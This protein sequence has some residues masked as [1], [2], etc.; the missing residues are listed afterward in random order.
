M[1]VALF[2]LLV[3]MSG[4]KKSSEKTTVKTPDGTME[5]EDGR[6]ELKTK[7]GSMVMASQELPEG[8]P[9]VVMNGA[10]I[11]SSTHMTQPD[12]QELFQVSVT[13]SVP[14][15]EVASFYEKMFKDKGITVSRTEQSG[16]GTQMIMLFGN[17]DGVDASAMI[18]K[19]ADAE[20][21]SATISWNKKKQ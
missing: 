6:M 4:C 14:V 17:S 7:D 10:K 11:A 12:G 13:T 8:C 18:V 5:V 1:R 16:Q 19:D 2:I 9:I 21:T 15:K 3:L 20:E